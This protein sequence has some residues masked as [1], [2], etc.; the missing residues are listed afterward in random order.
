MQANKNVFAITSAKHYVI[1]SDIIYLTPK[2]VN[3]FIKIRTY[4]CCRITIDMRRKV[5]QFIGNYDKL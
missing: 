3:T 4:I 1:V 5:L 2:K